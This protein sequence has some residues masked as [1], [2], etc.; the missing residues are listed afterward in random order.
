MLYLPHEKMGGD[1]GKGA[2]ILGLTW[3]RILEWRM[4]L[5]FVGKY[6]SCDICLNAQVE[7]SSMLIR[8]GREAQLV[9]ER[10]FGLCVIKDANLRCITLIRHPILKPRWTVDESWRGMKPR[11]RPLRSDPTVSVASTR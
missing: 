7:S 11:Q 10:G 1:G 8:Y 5:I 3:C 2:G 4:M 6:S 9:P